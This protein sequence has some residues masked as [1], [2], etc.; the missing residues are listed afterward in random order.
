MAVAVFG[1]T[2]CISGIISCQA[3]KFIC[4][5]S[6][7]RYKKILKEYLEKR[8]DYEK[9][10]KT[11]FEGQGW[12]NPK[13]AVNWE[14]LPETIVLLTPRCPHTKVNADK[15]DCPP[16]LACG[17]LRKVISL[18]TTLTQAKLNPY[19][20]SEETQLYLCSLVAAV[21]LTIFT[22]VIIPLNPLFM[23]LHL[24]LGLGAAYMGTRYTMRKRDAISS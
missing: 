7:K 8:A 9:Q 1:L 3:T 21:A 11:W 2:A 12:Q 14:N 24:L 5:E 18:E 13:K 16:H 17:L 19:M 4:E 23:T 20:K 22:S 6:D 15:K 10:W